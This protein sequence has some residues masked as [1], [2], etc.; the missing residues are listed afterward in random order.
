MVVPVLMTNCHV[1]LKWKR[2][3]LPAKTTTIPNAATKAP[4]LPD[5]RAAIAANC[6]KVRLLLPSSS[7]DQSYI[8]DSEPP[9]PDVAHSPAFAV[10]EALL[11][12]RLKL[13]LFRPPESG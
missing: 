5:A 10:A 9:D 4:R 2:G 7:L 8:Q 1:L 13:A 11:G 12:Y 6:P 3:P